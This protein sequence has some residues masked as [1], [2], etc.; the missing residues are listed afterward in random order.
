LAA[1]FVVA[2]EQGHGGAL[3]AAN[4]AEA[5]SAIELIAGARVSAQD[6]GALID[7]ATL[8]G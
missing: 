6:G 8:T 1:D 2:L 7:L 5:A 4:L 3:M